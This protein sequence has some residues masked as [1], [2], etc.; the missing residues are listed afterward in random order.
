MSS[1]LPAGPAR[2]RRI[3]WLA[4]QPTPYNGFLFAHLKKNVGIP[5]A[6]HYSRA[7]IADLPWKQEHHESSD[8]FFQPGRRLQW[9]LLRRAARE[10]D[11][12]FVVAGWE[13]PT[14]VAV[15]FLR[16]LRGLPFAIWT[17]TVRQPIG[18]FRDTIRTLVVRWLSRRAVAVLTTGQ[19]GVD[20]F[21]R[22]GLAGP[23]ARVVNFPFFV[24]LLAPPVRARSANDEI[25][26]LVC[27]RLVE[28]KGIDLAIKGLACSV[29]H[30][31]VRMSLLVAGAGPEEAKLRALAAAEGVADK[32]IFL[33]WVEA[34][35]MPAVREKAD[36]LLHVVPSHDPFPVAVL[37]AMA[38]GLPVVAS[39]LAGSAVE[40]V[41][42]GIS[43]FVIPPDPVELGAMM[44]RFAICP[45]LAGEMGRAARAVAEGWPVE[46]GAE[47]IR[48]IL[49]HN[50]T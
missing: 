26:F 31:P 12:L 27:G 48:R 11:T 32:V 42:D 40:R 39:P 49:E 2:C 33:G 6:V 3:T 17:D 21:L 19:V 15:M 18:V 10:R 34:A 22:S 46:R 45:K 24:P 4:V 16:A 5:I 36:V 8:F 14:K 23:G 1:T 37:E 20:A 7:T 50:A 35:D 41:Q 43:G 29:R 38:S 13:H 9:G 44:T 30:S 28:R 25:R 47:I